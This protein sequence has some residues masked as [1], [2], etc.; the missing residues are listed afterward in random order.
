MSANFRKTF[1]TCINCIMLKNQRL[2]ANTVDP[3]EMAHYEPSHLDLQC[4]QIQQLLYGIM[5]TIVV[6]YNR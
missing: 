1:N 6:I 4:L 3:D 2:E 5:E